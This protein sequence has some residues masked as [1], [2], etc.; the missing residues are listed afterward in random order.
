MFSS[1]KRTKQAFFSCIPSHG[2]WCMVG[3]FSDILHNGE[4]VGGLA[5]SDA[6]FES[7]VNMVKDCKM[8]ELPNHGNAFT[9]GGMRYKL[10]IQNKLDRSFGNQ[11]LFDIFPAANQAFLEKRGSDHIPVLVKLLA[12]QDTYKGK[13]RFDSRMLNKPRVRESIETVWNSV[14]RI[15]GGLVS[16][17]IRECRRAL[18]CWKRVNNC[19]A[20]DRIHQIQ[21]ALKVEQSRLRPVPYQV[22]RLKWELLQTYK[23]EENFWHQKSMNKWLKVGDGNTRFF[24]GSVKAKIAEIL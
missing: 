9:W 5:L 19:N 24:H 1:H 17:R 12:S 15:N 16:E 13:F 10:W 6:V 2:S 23:D 22:N 21:D 18:N 20:L 3:D 11:E 4:K 7:L 8:K 14:N